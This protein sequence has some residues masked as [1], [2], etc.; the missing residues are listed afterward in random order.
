M[1]TPLF[2]P[3]RLRELALDNRIVVSPMC[4]YSAVDGCATDWHLVHWGQLLESGAAMMI[5][6]ATAVSALGRI[7]P[8]CLGLYDDATE[9]ALTT[10]LA[11]ARAITPHMPV[12]IQLAHA[13]RK[14]SSQLP[15]EGG[16][17]LTPAQGAWTTLAPSALPHGVHDAAPHAFDAA[18]FAQV[19]QQFVVAT[20]R[21]VRCGIDAIE[22][23]MAHG[24]LMHQFLSPLSNQ[25]SD[26]YGGDFA[27]R[28]RFPLEVFGAVRAAWP[29]A[30]PLGV[31]ISST[32]WVEGGWT[33]AESVELSRLLRAAGVD[34]IDVS[35]GGISPLQQVPVG[36]GYQVPMA[37]EIRAATGVTTMAV[38]MITDAAQANALVADGSADLVALA[39]ALLWD[40]RWPWHAA[41]QL[42][43]AVNAP[44][45]Y[46]RA[47]PQGASAAL[48]KP[49]AGTR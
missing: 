22:L 30:K 18:T 1:T 13:G 11:R 42:G 17:A 16:Q 36:P 4:Q 29:V 44:P 21:A 25:R 46:W 27:G 37:R 5:I 23:H 40:P 28:T 49:R 33:V 34:W 35:S 2:S 32:D 24:Y 3:L 39:R 47:P 41:A 19:T 38:G 9:E 12:A 10:T 14:A 43:G 7:T 26:G 48:A 20:Q 31:R 6:E 8:R 45:Q 15:W